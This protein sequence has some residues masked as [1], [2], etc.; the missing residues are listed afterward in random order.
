MNEAI[1]P[2]CGSNQVYVVISIILCLRCHKRWSSAGA[3][4]ADLKK[5]LLEVPG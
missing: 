4:I 1:C 3:F 5:K 2:N